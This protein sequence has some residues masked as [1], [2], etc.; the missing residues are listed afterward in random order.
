MGKL[1][2]HFLTF[3]WR[4]AYLIMHKDKF[5]FIIIIIIIIIIKFYSS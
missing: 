3:S 5:T 1:Y 4:D 2:L